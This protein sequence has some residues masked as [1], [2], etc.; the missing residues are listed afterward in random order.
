MTHGTDR[1]REQLER[2]Y[3]ESSQDEDMREQERIVRDHAHLVRR[4]ARRF[5]RASG[6][7]VD[8]EDLTSVGMMGLLDAHQKYDPAGGRSF[9]V[10]A[11]FRVRGAIIDEMRRMD[12]MTQPMRR[13]ARA[14]GRARET[15]AQ[16]LGHSASEEELAEFMEVSLEDL[17]NMRRDLQPQIFVNNDGVVDIC[18]DL[19][20]SA[21][22]QVSLHSL[23]SGAIAYLPERLQ[24]VLA[25][26]YFEDLTLREIGLVLELTEAR[27][28]QLHKEAVQKMQ[29]YLH[30]EGILQ[31]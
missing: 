20:M 21:L 5:S 13:K 4:I 9:E 1:V 6:G 25:L 23:V 28:C 7:A 10:Y 31:R 19:V 3:A 16:Q 15:A 2:T 8:V 18:D 26:Y 30:S 29:K 12:P 14:L 22:D 11:E 27:V 17:Q 24:Q